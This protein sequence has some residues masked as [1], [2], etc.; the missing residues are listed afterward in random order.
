MEDKFQEALDFLVEECRN[1][2]K[3]KASD[4]GALLQRLVNKEKGFKPSEQ[5]HAYT[6]KVYYECR[7]CG[8]GLNSEPFGANYCPICGTKICWELLKNDKRN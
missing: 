2:K 5:L 1:I 4:Y 6:K 8:V 3:E 7:G